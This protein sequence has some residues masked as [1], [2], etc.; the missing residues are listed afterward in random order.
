MGKGIGN[1]PGHCCR[2]NAVA[3]HVPG[4]FHCFLRKPVIMFGCPAARTILQSVSDHRRILAAEAGGHRFG[5]HGCGPGCPLRLGNEFATPGKGKGMTLGYLIH[6]SDDARSIDLF[7]NPL[8]HLV[9]HRCQRQPFFPRQANL[10][11]DA[12]GMLPT[13]TAGFEQRAE[14]LYLSGPGRD[15]RTEQQAEQQCQFF[16]CVTSSNLCFPI[17]SIPSAATRIG[18]PQPHFSLP[19]RADTS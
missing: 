5:H 2:G 3:G 19:A 16:H 8:V 12:L 9:D 7:G 10:L 6:S 11:H 1:D 4:C 15:C 18:R 13:E 17:Q 14:V